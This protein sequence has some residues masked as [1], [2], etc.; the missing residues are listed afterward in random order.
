MSEWI[1]FGSKE[2]EY[3]QDVL[4]L[5]DDGS[6]EHCLYY[7]DKN[8]VDYGDKNYVERSQGYEIDTADA[9]YWIPFPALP[10][11]E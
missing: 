9:I 5:F 11:G 4:V 10:K 6:V 1:K 7:G 2:P 8:Y 3:K